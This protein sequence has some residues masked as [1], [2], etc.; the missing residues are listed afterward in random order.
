MSIEMLV[1]GVPSFL[2]IITIVCMIKRVNQYN[3]I[4]IYFLIITVAILTYRVS[5]N[6]AKSLDECSEE[7][8]SVLPTLWPG[9]TY[10]AD[11]KSTYLGQYMEFDK[12][13]VMI[14]KSCY[15]H[16][17]EYAERQGIN[18]IY[19]LTHRLFVVR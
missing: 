8:S 3:L 6:R 13:G 7:I 14:S 18:L 11:V 2:L 19:D 1:F 9:I 5:N 10:R 15:V 12:S 16:I 17:P 4:G